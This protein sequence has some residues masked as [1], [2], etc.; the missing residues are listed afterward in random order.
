M[1]L[2]TAPERP[3]ALFPWRSPIADSPVPTLHPPP[4]PAI[5][6][7][8]ERASAWEQL[9]LQPHLGRGEEGGRWHWP[10]AECGDWRQQ[11]QRV[12]DPRAAL[13]TRGHTWDSQDT[14]ATA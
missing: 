12:G 1:T 11:S 4:Y 6:L 5:P 8:Q 13:K 7:S 14:S 9:A 10:G 3:L 2:R